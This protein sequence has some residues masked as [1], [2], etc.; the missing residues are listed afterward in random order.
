[1]GGLSTAASHPLHPLPDISMRSR[2]LR[3]IILITGLLCITLAI[4]TTGFVLIEGYS[5]FEGF[6]IT[7]T[8][9]RQSASDEAALSTPS[10]ASVGID[11]CD[12]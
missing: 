5:S 8:L 2:L 3:R 12:D 7:L 11:T 4:G 1:M 10:K 9:L 6:Y